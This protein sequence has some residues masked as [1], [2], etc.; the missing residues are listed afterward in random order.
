MVVTKNFIYCIKTNNMTNKV[1]LVLRLSVEK[2]SKTSQHILPVLRQSGFL[3]PVLNIRY[4]RWTQG[5]HFGLQLKEKKKSRIWE[6]LNLLACGDS[7]TD[8]KKTYF[9]KFRLV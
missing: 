6:T 4:T 1:K 3:S 8:T 7:S 9:L 5:V 2:D